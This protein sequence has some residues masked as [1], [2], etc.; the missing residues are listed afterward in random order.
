MKKRIYCII[1]ALCIV[2][3]AGCSKAAKTDAAALPEVRN[4][5]T[6]IQWRYPA[7]EE[8]RDLV[9]L[10]ELR[11]AAGENGKDGADGKNGVDGR[12]GTNGKDG[13]SGIDGKNGIDGKD[14][15]DG[16]NGADGKD[17]INVTDGKNGLDGKDGINGTDGKDGTNGKDGIDGKDG[18]D[19]KDGVDGKDGINAKNIEVQRAESYIQWRYEGDE[20]QNLVAIADIEGP[21]GQNGT[22]GANGKTPEFRVSENIL[23]WRYVD[24]EIWL[25]LYDLSVLKGLDGKDGADGIN[26]KDGADGKDGTNGQNGSDGKD[27]KT[28]FIGENGNWWIGEIDTGIKAAGTDGKDGINGIDGTDGKQIEIQKTDLYI[29]WRY[30]GGEWQNLVALADILGPSGQNGTNGEDGRTP[31]FRVNGNQLQWRYEGETIWLNLY[32]LSALKGADGKDGSCAG[33]FAANGRVYSWGTPLPFN[34]KKES[35]DLISYDSS[36]KTITLSKGHT[37]S[38]VFSGTVMISANGNY[39]LCGA[40][41]IDGYNSSEMMLETRTYVSMIDDGQ[42]ARLGMS[43]NTIYRA[44]ENIALT[45]QYTNMLFQNT[46][47]TESQYN[48][49][50]IALD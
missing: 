7:E 44:E 25:N 39:K 9:A 24:D 50:I 35:G 16:K 37:Y 2:F 46:N 19:G 33:Y 14:G 1:I 3:A 45:F 43:Y 42:S 29:Q 28:P 15:V 36:S 31:E 6:A 48:I 8:W 13:I 38:M 17:G 4:N 5:G 26:G 32:D 18:A 30:K 41:L 20:W 34:V 11:G 47:F 21:A 22:D 12:N 40:S 23:Q 27:G 49:T 10:T